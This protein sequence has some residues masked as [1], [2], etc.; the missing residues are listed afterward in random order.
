[1][2]GFDWNI[3]E[4]A[5]PDGPGFAEFGYGHAIAIMFFYDRRLRE[6][7]PSFWDRM[8]KGWKHTFHRAIS[9]DQLNF[10]PAY[11][12]T[13]YNA[14]S[15]AW[16]RNAIDVLQA[17]L[18]EEQREE[19][20][21]PPAVGG[22][23]RSTQAANAALEAAAP[24]GDV[25]IMAMDPF[26]PKTLD[27]DKV[28]LPPTDLGFAKYRPGF[29]YALVFFF[30]KALRKKYPSFWNALHKGWTAVYKSPITSNQLI[31]PPVLG[32]IGYSQDE[33]RWCN[34]NRMAM[35]RNLTDQE[36]N[37]LGLPKKSRRNDEDDPEDDRPPRSRYSLIFFTILQNS[38]RFLPILLY[39]PSATFS[40]AGPFVSWEIETGRQ[41]R[42]F[43]G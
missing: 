7:Y 29:A 11:G 12:K 23:S 19:L 38:F 37:E 41:F 25:D 22:S 35:I 8:D 5:V 15:V 9:A 43:R 10:P 14:R 2:Q 1:M 21:I 40:L 36:R 3:Y 32:D 4:K 17:A 18:N 20:G 42:R 26:E 33:V 39:Q 34:V 24:P 13:A 31:H 28:P 27:F 6:S 30:S 16:C